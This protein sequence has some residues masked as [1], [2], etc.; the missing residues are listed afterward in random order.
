MKWHLAVLMSIPALAALTSARAGCDCP[1]IFC[2]DQ[3][4]TSWIFRPSYFSHDPDTGKR[5]DQYEP[6]QISYY[7]DDPTYM[8]SGYR[9]YDYEIYGP[10]GAADHLHVVQ[11]WGLGELI[12]PYGEWEFPYR[13][14]ATPYGP[15]GN[16]QGP[17]TLPFD[18][19]QNPY[20]LLQ[21]MQNPGWGPYRNGPQSGMPYGG[22]PGYGSGYGSGPGYG[23]G[24][25]YGTGY[26]G[27][28]GN[29]SGYGHGGGPAPYTPP[30]PGPGNY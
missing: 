6:E 26:G 30:N 21:Q 9:H 2:S 1:M 22:S 19:W 25:G 11:T 14:G 8:E 27:G 18:S 13:A 3:E 17:W 7:R 15:W 20:G 10:G 28:M 16:P 29:G 4:E 12:R 5:V 23:N 24:M